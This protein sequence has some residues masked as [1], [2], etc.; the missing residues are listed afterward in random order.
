[1]EIKGLS[2][3]VFY[4]VEQSDAK[5]TKNDSLKDISLSLNY[6]NKF[7][8]PKLNKEKNF[9]KIAPNE[10]IYQLDCISVAHDIIDLNVPLCDTGGTGG[11][12]GG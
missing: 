8:L 12:G 9:S 7:L 4:C 6:L 3:N 5:K 1:M 11:L 10:D 2:Q